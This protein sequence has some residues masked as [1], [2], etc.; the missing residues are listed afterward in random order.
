V[1]SVILTS[2]YGQS[3][4]FWPFTSFTV[5]VQASTDAPEH[6]YPD[7]NAKR[8]AIIGTQIL[9]S[10]LCLLFNRR[11]SPNQ[12]ISVSY[13]FDICTIPKEYRVCL[14]CLSMTH[15]CWNTHSWMWLLLPNAFHFTALV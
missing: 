2:L 11:V 10:I 5:Q 9:S 4:A 7:A 1:L 13:A 14:H 15:F 6:I 3:I 12:L 8:V